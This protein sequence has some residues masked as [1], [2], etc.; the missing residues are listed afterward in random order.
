MCKDYYAILG[1]SPEGEDVVIRA[2]YRALAQ[3]YHPDKAHDCDAARAGAHMQDLNEAY[4][5]LCS[6]AGRRRYDAQR[7]ACAGGAARPA[8]CAWRGR[9]G[10]VFAKSAFVP[11][12]DRPV[13]VGMSARKAPV[14]G[15]A[16]AAYIDC[17]NAFRT[18][19]TKVN[20]YA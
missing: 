19:K 16:T 12:N 17:N 20:V 6:G 18:D 10:A 7:S 5:A 9:C 14:D 15:A 13:A 2:A 3:R 4:A 11:Q 1:V 8:D